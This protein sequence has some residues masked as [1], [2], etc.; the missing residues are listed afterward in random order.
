ME[1]H[2]GATLASVKGFRGSLKT[3]GHGEDALSGSY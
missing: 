1:V 3:S 2:D